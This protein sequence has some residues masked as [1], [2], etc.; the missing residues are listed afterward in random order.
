MEKGQ[1]NIIVLHVE[2]GYDDRERHIER[3]LGRMGLKWEWML[4]G[5]IP[6][7]RKEDE[8][9]WFALS[10]RETHTLAEMSCTMKHLLAC[11]RILDA[12]MPGALILEDDIVLSKR[13]PRIFGASLEEARREGRDGG[14]ISYE[15]TRLQ[16]VPRSQRERG[17][18][19]YEGK[20]D[21]MAG[22]MYISAE[23]AR[24]VLEGAEKHKVDRPIDNFHN[25]LRSRGELPYYWCHPTVATQGS[26]TGLFP[27]SLTKRYPQWLTPLVWGFKINYK[28]LLYNLR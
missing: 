10:F 2:H 12:G 9:R 24:K 11:R 25:L 4:D 5:D 15:D 22:C 3:M 20:N 27:S 21:R 16:F 28:K 14:I 8:E 17:R 26:F 18:Y 1:V 23:G 13:F 19:L 6:K 7:L